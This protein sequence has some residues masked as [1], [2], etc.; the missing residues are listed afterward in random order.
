MGVITKIDIMDRGTDAKNMI[1][2][3]DIP[4]TLGYVGIKNRSQ[5]D[6]NNKVKVSAALNKEDEYF[7]SHP[8]YRNIDSRYLGTRA[9]TKRLT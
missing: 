2:N 1:M 8:V 4:L 5:E 3:K 6:I 9:L 7:R